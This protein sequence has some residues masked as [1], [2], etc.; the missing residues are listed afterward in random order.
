L[1]I[2]PVGTDWFVWY[3]I[4]GAKSAQKPWEQFHGIGLYLFFMPTKLTEDKIKEILVKE[5]YL[6]AKDL[7]DV[8]D[9]VKQT[10][11]GFV[12]Y[13]ID[14]GY[15][16][17]EILGQA[18]AEHYHL[19]YV[20]LAAQKIDDSLLKQL[21]EVVARNKGVV[22][23]EVGSKGVKVAMTDPT[24]L[25]ALHILEKLY[26]QT[27][28]PFFTMEQDLLD[29][30]HGYNLDLR[31]EFKRIASEME[32]PKLARE[33]RDN[34]MVNMVD[35]LLRYGHENKASDI[36]IE[37]YASKLIVRFR[38][39]G[40]MHEVLDISKQY[41][42]VLLTRIKI[43]SKMRI[44][45]HR[46]AQDGK[47]RF[48]FE[49]ENVD[50][51]VS[52]VPTTQGENIVMRL[53]SAKSRS[54]GLTDLGMGGKDLKKVQKA[55]KHPHGMFLVTG[56]TGSGKTTTLYAVLKILNRR[57]VNIAT[58]ED[59]VEYDI[60]GI[61]QIQVN[62]R[63]NLT[64]AQG[65]RSILR[66][67]PNII[68]VGEI[69]DEETAGIA[70]N[71]ALT[72]HLVLSTLHTNDAATTLPRLLDMHIEPFLVASTVNVAIA[73]RLV[74]KICS[75][76]RVSYELSKEEKTAVEFDTNI[77]TLLE[78]KSD[79]SLSKLRLYK[80][81]GCPVCNNTGYQGRIG[82]F[83][84]L[85][86]SEEIK[87]LILQ[88]ASSED[89]MKMAKSQGMTTMLEDGIDKVVNGGTTLEEVLRVTR[90]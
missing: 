11:L 7:K 69:R 79:K 28:L 18:L 48:K 8:E 30:L 58:I 16:T 33:E 87:K 81:Q 71:S 12:E 70:V 52:V 42:E 40:V 54:F 78:Q 36:H 57:D 13:L 74:R 84:I 64:F 17:K 63:T 23:F 83:E 19:V 41:A 65:L 6:A 85:E 77:K 80:G 21:P 35:T 20:N 3:N 45:E 5:T 27:I 67:D 73:Q 15:I 76:C 89:I 49:E 25:E 86:M 44:D 26:G 10:S 1:P 22:P 32:S 56:P 60:E 24:D 62:P 59:P 55:I 88:H 29:A 90:E 61:S 2:L 34:V 31:D 66:Q 14:N 47:L 72:G 4:I 68:M 38:I 82:V 46:A 9:E 43:L 75:R 39:D 51:R 53:L 50:V 37:P